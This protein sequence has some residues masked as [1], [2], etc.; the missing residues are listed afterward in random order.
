MRVKGVT[1]KINLQQTKKKKFD[2]N[3]KVTDK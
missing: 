3:K 1:K 2:E